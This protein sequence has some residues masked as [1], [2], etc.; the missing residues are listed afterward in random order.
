MATPEFEVKSL[1]VHNKFKHMVKSYGVIMTGISAEVVGQNQA[2]ISLDSVKK[3]HD[4]RQNIADTVKKEASQMLLPTNSCGEAS[5]DVCAVFLGTE[6]ASEFKA[7]SNYQLLSDSGDNLKEAIPNRSALIRMQV[8]R[9]NPPIT[10][11]KME[12]SKFNSLSA[13]VNNVYLLENQLLFLDENRKVINLNQTE[14]KCKELFDAISNVYYQSGSLVDALIEEDDGPDEAAICQLSKIVQTQKNTI[15]RWTSTHSFTIFVTQASDNEPSRL[16]PYQAYF[17]SHTLQDWFLG[18]KDERLSNMG[19]E[20]YIEKLA[21]VGTATNNNERSNVY[22]ELFAKP[23]REK[24]FCTNLNEKTQPLRVMFKVA[25]VDL[26]VTLSNLQEIQNFIDEN[27]PGQNEKAQCELYS[28]QA[29]RAMTLQLESRL[30]KDKQALITPSSEESH[31]T[32]NKLNITATPTQNFK[33]T[34]ERLADMKQ[35]AHENN[36]KNNNNTNDN[37]NDSKMSFG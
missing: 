8:D 5:N 33:E 26:K 37:D 35:Q 9:Y 28:S 6:I 15:N 2:A 18:D 36:N 3:G 13:Q 22:A 29:Q 31:D 1:Y 12:S 32:S 16:Y 10:Y 24:S 27:Y 4:I 34:K 20:T 14:N 23:G 25:E 11:S 17:G 19:S 30:L 7:S 21:L